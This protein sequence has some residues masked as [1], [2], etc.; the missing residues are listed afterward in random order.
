MPGKFDLEEQFSFY[1]AYHTN[2]I[3]VLIHIVC[4]PMILTTALLLTHGLTNK[5]LGDLRADLPGLESPIVYRLTIPS[6][7]AIAT[8]LYYITLEP[9][10]GLL[11]APVLVGLSHVADVAYNTN[12]QQAIKYGWILFV[13]SWIAQFIGHG[14]FEG[15]APA[16]LD[17][18]FQSLVLAVFFVWLEVLFFLGYKPSLH[19]RLQ[20]KISHRVLEH[21]RAKGDFKRAAAAQ[22]P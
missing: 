13:A 1:G 4:V 16:L 19:R 5:S 6:I 15:R 17:S 12:A 20:N 3:N 11:Y 21:R 22:N 9:L 14:K 7:Y 18:L 2:K 10:A 8:A